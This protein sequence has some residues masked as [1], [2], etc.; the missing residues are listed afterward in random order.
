MAKKIVLGT[1]LLVLTTVCAMALEIGLEGS[2]SNLNFD[3]DRDPAE[4]G[5]DPHYL[6]IGFSL[7][8]RHRFDDASGME[9]GF[10]SDRIIK[11]ILYGTFSYSGSYYTLSVGPFLGLFNTS[12][13]IINP[14]VK[15]S[16]KLQI[17]GRLF[18]LLESGRTLNLLNIFS[19]RELSGVVS[20][21]GDYLQEDNNVSF[22]FYAGS[23]IVSFLIRSR[24]YTENTAD[25]GVVT[26]SLTDYSLITDI[27]QKNSP[28]KVMISFTYRSLAKV[29]EDAI[30]KAE[31]TVGSLVLG[32]R[33][34]Y[35]IRRD[36]SA[37]ALLES[38]LYSFG[39]DDLIGEFGST[40]YI[41]TASA[42]VRIDL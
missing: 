22:G 24:L 17:P 8:G 10:V 18:F 6:P 14:G 2:V 16:V 27:F 40:N 25:Y 37:Y 30:P 36:I 12:S 3:P 28:F 31:H 33:L 4:T 21:T 42:G 20:G 9:V 23:T 13:M 32:T 15:A 34:D 41:F 26:D 7:Y 11:N 5:F 19:G 29:F 1:I 35:E 39:L 38:S